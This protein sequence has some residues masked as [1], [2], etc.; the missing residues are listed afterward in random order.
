MTLYQWNLRG[1]SAAERPRGGSSQRLPAS[2]GREQACDPATHASQAHVRIVAV[3]PSAA[4]PTT[5]SSETRHRS[6]GG[7]ATLE[8][9][10]EGLTFNVALKPNPWRLGHFSSTQPFD[11]AFSNID[12]SVVQVTCIRW[13]LQAKEFLPAP[14]DTSLSLSH[15]SF[16]MSS[17]FAS[18]CFGA[19]FLM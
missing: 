8:P 2:R 4:T 3:S 6:R 11:P 1:D 15:T 19:Q 17:T 14:A 10:D 7:R 12:F 5:E 18:W 16:L 13:A 9:V